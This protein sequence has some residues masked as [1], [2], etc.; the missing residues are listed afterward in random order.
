M[1]LMDLVNYKNYRTVLKVT[2]GN[3]VKYTDRDN[4]F[5]DIFDR[6]SIH[7]KRG[8]VVSGIMFGEPTFGELPRKRNFPACLFIKDNP[9][10]IIKYIEQ[11][12]DK[13][14][15]FTL[16]EPY[17][18]IN[19]YANVLKTCYDNNIT[20]NIITSLRTFSDLDCLLIHEFCG[21][22]GIEINDFK[23]KTMMQLSSEIK[24]LLD[25][26]CTV[27]LILNIKRSLIDEL[28]N[29]LKTNKF[30]LAVTY[31][32]VRF[33]KD[34]V[35]DNKMLTVSKCVNDN[36]KVLLELDSDIDERIYR[37]VVP[38][39]VFNVE[40]GRFVAY[41]EDGLMRANRASEN[42]LE[43]NTIKETWDILTKGVK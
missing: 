25:Y 14:F 40:G 11:C 43:I 36:P 4:K 31:I 12:K 33:H 35:M 37:S 18:Y 7:Y 24:K 29:I 8:N 32:I 2:N 30:G 9:D 20:P 42:K 23:E 34:V 22:I 21:Y 19:D 28:F 10:N 39:R 6:K 27:V 41:I 5:I 38:E 17:L 13:T 1:K 15:M 16:M 3:I 26:E